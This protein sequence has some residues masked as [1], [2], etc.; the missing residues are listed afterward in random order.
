MNVCTASVTAL[1]LALVLS[2]PAQ[3]ETIRL[4]AVADGF[5]ADG[6]GGAR[7]NGKSDGIAENF[8]TRV[9][10][11]LGQ[12]DQR[13]VIHFD[14]N[15][16]KGERVQKATLRLD[17]V[18]K[19]TSQSAVFPIEV[20]GYNSFGP[21]SL[22][23][24]YRGTFIKVFDGVKA[25]FDRPVSIDVTD[26]VKRGLSSPAGMI[27]FTLRSNANGTVTFGSIEDGAV[28]T[29]RLIVVTE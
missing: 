23:D 24:F 4:L 1:V 19:E 2:A 8:G 20:R 5:V 3:A 18:H 25:P 15:S 12:G 14:V 17:I 27:G 13:A 10:F 21:I 6:L 28:V 22:G 9:S 29:P 7:L 26:R 16:L 11:L